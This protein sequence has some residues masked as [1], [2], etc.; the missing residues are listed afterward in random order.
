MEFVNGTLAEAKVLVETPGVLIDGM[1]QNRSDTDDVCGLGTPEECIFQQRSAQFASLLSLVDCET[2]QQDHADW[3]IGLTFGD[4]ASRFR[5]TDRARAQ[6][7]VPQDAVV[8]VDYIRARRFRLLASQGKT[9]EPIVERWMFPT[10]KLLQAVMLLEEFNLR[11]RRLNVQG[12]KGRSSIS[13]SAY[14][15]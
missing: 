4:P 2:G 10:V 13:L 14:G 9:L 6:R 1:H 3:M 7:V 15:A 8:P 11:K 5:F 12:Q